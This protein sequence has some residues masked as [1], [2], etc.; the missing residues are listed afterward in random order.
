MSLS[1]H[2]IYLQRFRGKKIRKSTLTLL[3]ILWFFWIL[4][5]INGN[6]QQLHHLKQKGRKKKLFLNNRYHWIIW[7]LCEK[8]TFLFLPNLEQ[9]IEAKQQYCIDTKI[10]AKN[11]NLKQTE[12]WLNRI[13]TQSWNNAFSQS[14]IIL[15]RVDATSAV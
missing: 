8:F 14:R 7:F 11:T 13:P 2:S 3:K 4:F 9:N 5:C 15:I 1:S 12:N 6:K 10:K